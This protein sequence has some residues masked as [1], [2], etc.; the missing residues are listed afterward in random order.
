MSKILT[1]EQVVQI[2]K[3]F[4]AQAG[5]QEKAAAKIG[6]TAVY[7]GNILRGKQPPGKSIL[8]FFGI[9]RELIYK[10]MNKK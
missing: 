1:Q 6:V 9:E 10:T 8:D 3:D 2:L 7:I 4:V 5:T